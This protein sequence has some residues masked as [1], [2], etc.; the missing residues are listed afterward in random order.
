M[1]IL[2]CFGLLIRQKQLEGFLLCGF[3][4]SSFQRFWNLIDTQ[5]NA[6]LIK[7]QKPPEIK[8][9]SSRS[10]LKWMG[11]YLAHSPPFQGVSLKYIQ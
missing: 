4:M 8:I 3:V 9:L 10:T 2:L 11:S 1:K 7:A 5:Q 6:L